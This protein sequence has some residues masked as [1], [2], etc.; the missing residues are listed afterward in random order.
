MVWTVSFLPSLLAVLGSKVKAT[1]NK[2]IL[3]KV[4]K[5]SELLLEVCIFY[6]HY[7]SSSLNEGVGL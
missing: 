7:C 5:A 1:M 2:R 6:G 4:E 3:M